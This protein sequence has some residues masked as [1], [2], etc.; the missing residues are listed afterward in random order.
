M[1][2]TFRNDTGDTRNYYVDVTLQGEEET[3]ADEAGTV[4]VTLA[5]V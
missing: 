2:F 5:E 4:A 3:G 1:E